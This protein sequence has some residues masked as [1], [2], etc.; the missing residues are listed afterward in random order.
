[1]AITAA[2][3]YGSGARRYH[4]GRIDRFGVA[5]AAGSGVIPVTG[6][7]NSDVEPGK[8]VEVVGE[9]D[10]ADL[11]LGAGNADGAHEQLHAVLLSGEDMLDGR[12]YR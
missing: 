8:S 3:W 7:R 2:R 9:V 12:A 11:H 4:Q 5:Q 6:R 1:M 10:H